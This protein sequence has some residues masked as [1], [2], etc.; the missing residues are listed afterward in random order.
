ME[1][2]K[3]KLLILSLFMLTFIGSI[4]V[5]NVQALSLQDTLYQDDNY[6]YWVAIYT[7]DNTH[8]VKTQ[9]SMIRRISD[10]AAVYCIQAPIQFNSGSSVNGIVDS[11]TMVSM[12]NLSFEQMDRIKLISYYGYGYG[13]HTSPEWYYAT[14]LLIWSVTNPGYVYAIADND[15]SLTPSNR[16]DSYYNEINYLVDH[17]TTVPS[18]ARQKVEVVA[19]ETITLTDTN[20]VL[21]KY[22]EGV[23]NDNYTAT[24]QG[25]KLVIQ[26]KKGY[27]GTIDLSV[28]RN[29]NPP[30]IYEGANQLC[31]N[32]GDPVA[33]RVRLNLTITTHFEGNKFYGNKTDGY[34]RPEKNAEFE[35][36]NNETNELITTLTSNENGK[37]EYNLKLG[38]Y[39]LH[40]I[41]GKD[42]F[43]LVKDYIFTVDGSNIKETIYFKNEQIT[44][45]LEFS[46][47]DISTG[48]KLPNTLIEIRK[49]DT[50]EL[51]FSGRT[52]EFG[53][54]TI[55]DLEYGKYY[56]IEKEAPEGY[57]I[58]DEK[59]YFEILEDGKVVKA[60]MKDS[61][62]EM[63]TTFNTDL[64]SFIILGGTAL[65]GLCLTLYGKKR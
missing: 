48:E 59:I 2:I 39:R 56:I 18:F 7:R 9:E 3:K 51:V 49:A 33:T 54:I 46:K 42:G 35:L 15:A 28:K 5:L 12:T 41:K 24:V 4:P 17:H 50:D 53:K 21:S 45:T 32:A 29:D 37:F 19:G 38:T 34:Y 65:T 25:N 14:Q 10:N 6:K 26:A 20:N 27:E 58:N 36:Y 57:N 16:Y 30:M 61:K 40:Q 63:P 11:N 13:S 31:M 64:I 62:I 1:R 23:S 22:Y 43:Q 47:E 8:M 55:T 52:D 60:T 44:G